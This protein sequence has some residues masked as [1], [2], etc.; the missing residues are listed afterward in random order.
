MHTIHVLL[1]DVV[2]I[3]DDCHFLAL[4]DCR[5][6]ERLD[7]GKGDECEWEEEGGIGGECGGVF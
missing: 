7:A 5:A 4:D 3:A 1:I 2:E 6:A